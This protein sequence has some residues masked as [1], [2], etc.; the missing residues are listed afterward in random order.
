MQT[1]GCFRITGEAAHIW[2][3]CSR[4]HLVVGPEKGQGGV[5]RWPLT[6]SLAIGT[7]GRGAD[8][9]GTWRG[10]VHTVLWILPGGQGCVAAQKAGAGFEQGLQGERGLG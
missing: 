1:K 10:R 5:G 4:G 2:E 3:L 9:V 7:E 8:T 6:D